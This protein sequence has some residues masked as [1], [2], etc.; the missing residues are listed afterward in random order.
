MFGQ[1]SASVNEA[2]TPRSRR[3]VTKAGSPKL[4]M[5][6]L[7]HVIEFQPVKLA[8]QVVEESGEVVAIELLERREL[9]QHRP[10]LRR[11]ARRGPKSTKRRMKSPVSASSFCWVTRRGPFTEKM[12]PSGAAARPFAEAVGLC[13]R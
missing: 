3:S 4:S 12:K 11:L 9:P 8:R 5:A 2:V 10:E 1:V 6:R 13:S 7:N